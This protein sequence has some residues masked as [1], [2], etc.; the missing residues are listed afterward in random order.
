MI[1]RSD[2]SPDQARIGSLQG[3]RTGPEVVLVLFARL[4][5]PGKAKT[6]LAAGVGREAAAE[7]YR[8]CAEHAFREALR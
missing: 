8:A 2:L 7:F 5:V 4:P 3:D 6:R 1:K